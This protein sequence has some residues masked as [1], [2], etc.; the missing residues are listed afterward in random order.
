MAWLKISESS[1]SLAAQSKPSMPRSFGTTDSPVRTASTQWLQC[2]RSCGEP[3][4][5]A[6]AAIESGTSHRSVR[7]IATRLFVSPR[8]VQSHLTHIY[9]KLGVS[10]RVQLVQ[11]AARHN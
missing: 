2:S 10:S 9:N 1:G 5:R 4:N 3:T 11:E 8:T 7:A 6:R